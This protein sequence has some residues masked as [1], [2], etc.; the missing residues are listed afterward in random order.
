MFCLYDKAIALG[1]NTANDVYNSSSEFFGLLRDMD[2][3]EIENPSND[4][5]KS[6]TGI[7]TRHLATFLGEEESDRFQGLF[8][9]AFEPNSAYYG[10][11][12]KPDRREEI[13]VGKE[14]LLTTPTRVDLL[15]QLEKEQQYGRGTTF[16]VRTFLY[17]AYADAL[18]ITLTPDAVRTPVLETVLEKEDSYR[19]D[20]LSRFKDKWEKYPSRGEVEL[21]RKVSPFAA[22]V[23]NRA[24]SKGDIPQEMAKLRYE[25]EALRKDLQKVE[26]QALWWTSRDEAIRAERKWNEVLTEIEMNFG[27]DPRLVTIKRGLNFAESVGGVVEKPHSPKS[28]I[29][30]ITGPVYDI[31]KRFV[32][33]GPAIEIHALKSRLQS[34][35]QLRKDIDRLFGKI[36][37]T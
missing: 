5:A 16:L 22:V 29:Q 36:Q 26:D 20:I 17:L 32:A 35:N 27:S 6:I 25:T 15:E 4:I 37:D 13:Q 3:I 19:A 14:W 21:R 12:Y 28:W 23:F 33:R 7:A 2:F 1:R 8:S 18:K 9:A 31:V 11:T 24:E 30:T 34:P 10:L